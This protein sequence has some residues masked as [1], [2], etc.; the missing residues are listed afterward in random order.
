MNEIVVD[1]NKDKQRFEL[2]VPFMMSGVAKNMP[3][4][5][6]NKAARKWFAP[7]VRKNAEYIAKNIAKMSSAKVTDVAQE[8][9]TTILQ[10][11][12]RQVTNSLPDWYKPK[13]AMRSYQKECCD[14]F[15]GREHGL[16]FMVMGS[17]KTK[18]TIDIIAARAMSSGELSIDTVVIACP[19][20]IRKNWL[21]ELEKHCPIEYAAAIYDMSKKEYRDDV[22]SMVDS[23][24]VLRILIVGIESLSTGSAIA[25]V[26]SFVHTGG[27]VAFVVDELSKIKTHSSKRTRNIIQL[28]RSAKLRLGLTGTPITQG[29]QDLYSQLEFASPDIIGYGDY[30]SF[31][32][33]YIIMGGFNEKQ[34]IGYQ[35]V[36][37]LMSSIRP[38]VYQVT[39]KQAMPELL[40]RTYTVRNV[41]LSAEQKRVYNQIKNDKTI[42]SGTDVMTVKNALETMLRLQQVTG[43]FTVRETED[44]LT[45]LRRIEPVELGSN[46]ITELLSIAEESD[47]STIVWARFRPEIALIAKA[48]REKYGPDSVVEF[49]GGLD[50]QQRWHNVM[51]FETGQARFFVGNQAT[52]GMGLNLV[53]ASIAVF[54]SNTFSLEDREQAEARNF[55]IRQKNAVTYI[56]LTCDDTVDVAITESLTN[57]K[58]VADYVKESF[59]TGSQVI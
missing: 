31:R 30:Y 59:A 48:L 9:V 39:Q 11:A 14:M 26:D 52:G 32:N 54:Y 47:A 24:D 56:D 23:S 46:K 58:S 1:Y 7:A 50:Q 37:E 55:R 22:C 38:Y 27:N 17:G 45:G 36:D 21:A 15:Y 29:I 2:V 18:A 35:N 42:S 33:R 13:M 53:R 25:A 16:L 44:A 40:E 3:T 34:I 20:S 6:W 51:L 19:C 28:S 5:K 41:A 10:K 43:G 12:Q 8:A 4:R 57:K 49:H